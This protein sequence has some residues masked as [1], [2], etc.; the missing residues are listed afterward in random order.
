M[1]MIFNHPG[2]ISRGLVICDADH[3]ECAEVLCVQTSTAT[4]QMVLF[5]WYVKDGNE[6]IHRFAFAKIRSNSIKRNAQRGLLVISKVLPKFKTNLDEA[7]ETQAARPKLLNW[8]GA[9]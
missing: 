6:S 2:K 7:H 3:M 1:Q 4:S 9:T 5:E 8:T